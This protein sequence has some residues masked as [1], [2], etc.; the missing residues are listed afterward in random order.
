M[1]DGRR[2]LMLLTELNCTQITSSIS[3][4]MTRAPVSIEAHLYEA[5]SVPEDVTDKRLRGRQKTAAM[6]TRLPD[7]LREQYE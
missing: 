3:K 5:G 7:I 4:N 6:E 1:I 2:G